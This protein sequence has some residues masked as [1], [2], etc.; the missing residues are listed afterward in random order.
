MT[1]LA[2][3]L[4][5]RVT[6]LDLSEEMLDQARSKARQRGLRVEF[7]VGSST[8]PPPGPFDAVMERH[9]LWTTPDPVGALSAWRASA[10]AGRLVLFEGIWGR[11]DIVQ[12]TRDAAVGILQRLHHIP[13][14]HH[15]EYD[16]EVL[17]QLPLARLPSAEPLVRA[18]YDAGWRGARIQRLLDVEW[19]RRMQAPIGLAWLESIPQFALVADA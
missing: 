17:A 10:P 19:A 12:R 1:L 6:A 5:Y 11:R 13:H 16:P 4:G 3:E 2:A 9:V 7:V 15:A 14:D 18:V 8:A